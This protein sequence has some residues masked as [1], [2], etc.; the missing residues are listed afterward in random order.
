MSDEQARYVIVYQNADFVGSLYQSATNDGLPNS[1]QIETT[2][3]SDQARTSTNSGKGSAKAAVSL[4]G[5]TKLEANLG[6][7]R[8]SSTKNSL[9]SSRRYRVEVSRDIALYLH[10]LHLLLDSSTRVIDSSVNIEELDAGTLV[11]FRGSFRPD[12]IS[13][14]L[15]LGSPNLVAEITRFS[16]RQS[17]RPKLVEDSWDI[18][19]LKSQWEL[20]EQEA[21]TKADLARTIADAVRTDFRRGTTT[22][23]HCKI[24][25]ALTALVVCEA[26]HFITADPDRPLDGEFTVFGKVITRP[27]R[28][29]PIFRKNKLL[30]RMNQDW[31]QSIFSQITDTMKKS[32]NEGAIPEALKKKSTNGKTPP[33]FDLDFPATIEGLS[34]TV[35]PI[36]IYV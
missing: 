6:G 31:V 30:S 20:A 34:F 28:D 24:N 26:E 8:D 9:S 35:L 15:D 25:E 5:I 32:V 2:E 12:P 21:T 18:D 33:P 16:V 11:K 4:P 27:E 10:H 13:A 19:K 36:A 23:F 1:S 3:A 29:V 22:E 14:L 7:G 17:S